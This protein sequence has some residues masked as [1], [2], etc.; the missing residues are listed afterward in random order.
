MPGGWSFLPSGDPF[1]TRRVKM[2]GVY[3]VAWLPRS[4]SRQHRRRTGLFAPTDTIVAAEAMARETEAT[5]AKARVHN[6]AGRERAE[7]RYR[8][9][10][11][12]AVFAWLNFAPQFETL[13]RSIAE[14]AAA[15]ATTVGSGRVG[16]TRTLPLEQRV[17]LAARAHV[18]HRHTEYHEELD[19]L[20]LDALELDDLDVEGMPDSRQYRRVKRDASRRVDDFLRRCRNPD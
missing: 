19:A 13:A 8:E 15:R 10:F 14:G 18:R 17:R 5:R 20:I 1:V 7:A 9:E 6:A 4:R 3:W 12:E 11:A 2:A 16:R